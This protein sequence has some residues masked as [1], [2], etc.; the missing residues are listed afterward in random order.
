MLK[1]KTKKKKKSG[2]KFKLG[3]FNSQ[4]EDLK[5]KINRYKNL[6]VFSISCDLFTINIYV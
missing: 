6:I 4:D 5:Q 3:D 2:L 1:Q